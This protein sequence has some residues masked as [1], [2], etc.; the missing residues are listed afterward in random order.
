MLAGGA[1]LSTGQSGFLHF[2]PYVSMKAGRY[3]L[4]VYGQADK[5][6]ASWVDIVGG[7]GAVVYARVPFASPGFDSHR[8]EMALETT[9]VIE[10]SM[11]GTRRSKIRLG[12][13]NY[14]NILANVDSTCN[15]NEA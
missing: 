5:P 11:S 1:I 9:Y 4:E 14:P 2:G 3:V 7:C 12:I 15:I 10:F 13:R 8:H 6:T